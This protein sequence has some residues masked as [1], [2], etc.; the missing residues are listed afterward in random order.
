[1]FTLTLPHPPIPPSF[2]D[3]KRIVERLRRVNEEYAL[4][5]SIVALTTR[6]KGG[7]SGGGGAGEAL[8]MMDVDSSG[9][10]GVMPVSPPRA[11]HAL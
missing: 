6:G 8:Y 11:K 2:Q 5:P 10:G 9:G 7:G 3:V 4:H 1:V